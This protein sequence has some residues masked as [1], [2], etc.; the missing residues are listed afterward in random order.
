MMKTALNTT[1][2]IFANHFLCVDL[3]GFSNLSIKVIEKNRTEIFLFFS[4]M[5]RLTRDEDTP[6]SLLS[7]ERGI[8]SIECAQWKKFDIGQIEFVRFR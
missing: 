4:S 3:V 1:R 2:I 7:I 5:R 6:I 8:E